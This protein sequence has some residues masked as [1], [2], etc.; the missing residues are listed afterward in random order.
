[1]NKKIM[2]IIKSQNELFLIL[3]TNPKHMMTDKWFVVTGSVKSDESE[4]EAVAREVEEETGLKILKIQ[5]T[6]LS[7]KYEWPL[8]S[9][10]M[11]HEKAFLVTA[12]EGPIKLNRWEHLDYQW[13]GKDEFLETI[14]WQGDKLELGKI[15]ARPTKAAEDI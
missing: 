14:A 10:K 11:H 9:S 3:K 7:F 6:D 12:E 4:E 1:M 5:P 13:L 15:L 8:G 2:A